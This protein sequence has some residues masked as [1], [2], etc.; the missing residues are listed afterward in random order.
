MSLLTEVQEACIR[1]SLLLA[2]KDVSDMGRQEV[3]K[4]M[5]DLLKAYYIVRHTL[6]VEGKYI[7][8]VCDTLNAAFDAAINRG[9]D[10]GPAINQDF[11]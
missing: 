3:S 9:F 5:D 10:L 11:G 8:R 7:D 4:H 2:D 1:N 6:G